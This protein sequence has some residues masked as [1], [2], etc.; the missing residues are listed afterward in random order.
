MRHANNALATL[1][2]IVCVVALFP[3]VTP[4]KRL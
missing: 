4:A 2:L 3:W 1:S